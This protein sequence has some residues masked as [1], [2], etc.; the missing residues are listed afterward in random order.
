MLLERTELASRALV[1]SVVARPRPGRL[2]GSLPLSALLRQHPPPLPLWARRRHQGAELPGHDGPPSRVEKSV[3]PCRTTDRLQL[4][5]ILSVILLVV[6]IFRPSY[7]SVEPH[8][9]FFGFSPGEGFTRFCDPMGNHPREAWSTQANSQ[10]GGTIGDGRNE[11]VCFDL[12]AASAHDDTACVRILTKSGIMLWRHRL[13]GIITSKSF[14][15][16]YA[17]NLRPETWRWWLSG[18]LRK[19]LFFVP[20]TG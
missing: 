11:R 5:V 3:E 2:R 17:R 14:N 19:H 1:H 8:D 10:I 7:W 13:M 12:A 9:R 18:C 6:L 20:S 15:E 16:C 4:S